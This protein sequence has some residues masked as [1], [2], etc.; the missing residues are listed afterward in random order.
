[1]DHRSSD[2]AEGAQFL[3]DLRDLLVDAEQLIADS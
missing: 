1:M 2:G 3:A